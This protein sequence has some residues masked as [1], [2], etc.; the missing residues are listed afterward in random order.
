MIIYSA[1]GADI[2][3]YVILTGSSP[4]TWGTRHSLHQ[5][6]H[7]LRF[8]PAHVGNTL[9]PHVGDD[10]HR[11]SWRPAANLNL[12]GGHEPPARSGIT[13]IG[14]HCIAR[15]RYRTFV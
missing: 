4:R 6:P 3:I 2:S 7:R 13:L 14:F 15:I 5:P 8:I 10:C 1:G 12:A 11:I 9:R